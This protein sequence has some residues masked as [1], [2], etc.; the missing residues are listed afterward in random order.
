[1]ERGEAT[2]KQ[3]VVAWATNCRAT[4]KDVGHLQCNHEEAD[5]KIILHTVDATDDDVTELSFH[6]ADT[7]VLVLTIR[8]Y[9]EMCPDTSFVT[10]SGASRRTI[11]LKPIVEALGP[12]KT[13]P[14]PAFHPLT[15]AENT[16][17]F[18]GKGKMTSKMRVSLALELYP[19]SVHKRS[20]KKKL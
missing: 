18:A 5:T 4:Y 3:V 1:M 20:Q 7:D 9:P 19:I 17:S 13:A 8:R 14:L 6:S 12:A 16:G 11:K 10:G 15:G 2:G